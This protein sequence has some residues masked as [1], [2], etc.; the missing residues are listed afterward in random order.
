M[1][2]AESVQTVFRAARLPS[3]GF[4]LGLGVA[5]AYL[6][7][8]LGWPDDV[9]GLMLLA[10]NA[11]VIALLALA[12]LYHLAALAQNTPALVADGDGFLY[13]HGLE[14]TGPVPW[15]AVHDVAWAGKKSSGALVIHLTEPARLRWMLFGRVIADRPGSVRTL[16]ILPGSVG[17]KT[18]AVHRLMTSHLQRRS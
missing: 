17:W 10:A 7:P 6:M 16:R 5:I 14:V 3:L 2:R 8:L 9:L 18:D 11:A 12:V 15:G 1:S 13:R 4:V